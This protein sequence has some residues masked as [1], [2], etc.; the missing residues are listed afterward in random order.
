MFWENTNAHC[1][2]NFHIFTNKKI[3]LWQSLLTMNQLASF[4]LFAAYT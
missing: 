2:R 3:V 1:A 4:V